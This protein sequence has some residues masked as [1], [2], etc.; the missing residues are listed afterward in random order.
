MVTTSLTPFGDA[1]KAPASPIGDRRSITP[2][3]KDK[4]PW[5]MPVPDAGKK[6]Y[7]LCR[8]ASYQAAA[9]GQ[10]P[11]I[12]IGGKL[13]ALPRVIERQL[14]EAAAKALPHAPG[15]ER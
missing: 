3:A 13:L 11:T 12:R 10:I 5:T 1:L 7:D 6:Y 14:E 15:G 2:M 8:T 4:A 9:K